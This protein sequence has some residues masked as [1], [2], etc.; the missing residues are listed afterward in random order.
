MSVVE[1][2]RALRRASD[3]EVDYLWARFVARPVAAWLLAAWAGPRWTPNGVSLAS[4]V[5]GLA[6]C[7]AF[8]W[9]PGATGLWVAF[10]LVQAAFVLDCMD[11]MLARACDLRSPAGTALD[12]L[13]DA[14]KQMALFPA[15]AWR[16]WLDAGRPLDG[17]DAW[18][19]WAAVVSGPVV[20][21]GLAC[22]T[23]LRS[24]EVTGGVARALRPVRGG[25]LRG[26]VG[27]AVSFLMNYPSWI[28]LPV[29]FRRL[30]VFLLVSLPLYAAYLVAALA[31]IARRTATRDHYAGK[32]PDARALPANLTA[33][34]AR[35]TGPPSDG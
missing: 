35:R 34:S 10:S 17:A 4:L 32:G 28:L 2:A 18:P 24:P 31:L 1:R 5:V 29:L 8:A 20:A 27:A 3:K 22:T 14:L 15:V 19:L 13:V 25:D 12:F 16:V 30:D 26:R 11:G 21:A 33:G 7:A 6:A 23:F 9:W